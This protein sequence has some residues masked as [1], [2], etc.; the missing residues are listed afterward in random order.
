MTS[1]ATAPNLLSST[2][3]ARMS[4]PTHDIMVGAPRGQ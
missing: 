3:P 4:E 2:K 1:L